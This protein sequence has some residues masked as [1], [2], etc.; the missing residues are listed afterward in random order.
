MGN[1]IKQ[2]FLKYLFVNY[3]A[4]KIFNLPIEKFIRIDDRIDIDDEDL[5]KELVFNYNLIGVHLHLVAIRQKNQIGN[6]L[7]KSS[8]LNVV[9]DETISTR[10]LGEKRKFLLNR[11]E[12]QRCEIQA[13][14]GNI[15]NV[16]H[17]SSDGAAV[18]LKQ[19][20]NECRNLSLK[21]IVTRE[22][23]QSELKELMPKIYH[24]TISQNPIINL[25]DKLKKAESVDFCFLVDCT[26]SMSPYIDQVEMTINQIVNELQKKFVNFSMRLAFVGYRDFSEDEC[27]RII[28][29]GFLQDLE[30]FKLLVSEIVAFGGDDVCED[31]FIGLNEVTKL[32]WLNESRV[33]FHI[34][35]AP[36]HGQ[37]FHTDDIQDKYLTTEHP[38]GF[39]INTLM[40][41]LCS[42]NINYFFAEINSS[43]KLMVDEFNRELSRNGNLINVV[44]LGE[45]TGRISEDLNEKV[46]HS[47]I[48]VINQ[49]KSHS[50]NPTSKHL[51]IKSRLV[52]AIL[53]KWDDLSLFKK[54]T[55]EYY[56]VNNLNNSSDI[57][58]K[59]A[60][61]YSPIVL[62]REMW[63]IDKPF[64]KGMLRFA[65][66][67]VL[68]IGYGNKD[69]SVLLNC[70][71]KESIS[72]E[73]RYNTKQYH[74]E[75]LE[76]Q[77]I[78]NYLAFK[79][80]QIF[81]SHKTKLR[82]LDVDLIRV[83]E[84]GEYYCIEEF[85]EGVFKKWS[86]NEGHVNA[87]EYTN[88]LSA[89]SHWTYQ[90]TGEY[91]II[92][93]LQGFVYKND[94]YILTD[95]AILCQEDR[96]GS[97]NLGS[98]GIRTFF[99]NHKC[100]YICKDLNLRRNSYQILPDDDFEIEY[101]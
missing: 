38:L 7:K 18:R 44:K 67:A 64:A 83:K 36:C 81:K 37:R 91:L 85:V 88:L 50:F 10:E 95:P 26:S 43:T 98:S 100:N 21:T 46:Q 15:K 5:F 16:Q 60:L 28:N 39:R 51:S 94:E 53:P 58:T 69:E 11:I 66:P 29:T 93:D 4:E 62:E 96:F 34:C 57:K 80:G 17:Q 82:F 89:F 61:T 41:L 47:I 77:V 99:F 59:S 86:N 92:T 48:Q 72:L 8:I 54:Y 27:D 6:H 73:P 90:Y 75:S 12:K 25:R 14:N 22:T 55:V 35:D 23:P 20:E 56:T 32:E 63:K 1:V 31:V 3:I 30:T 79:F 45:E 2:I 65:Y 49:T 78:S 24:R 74:E 42:L 19:I 97:T 76:I 70:V 52:N 40:N 68:N 101:F 33:L 84:T 71:V 9:E 87:N 13:L